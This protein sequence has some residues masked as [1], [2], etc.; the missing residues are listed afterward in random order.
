[1]KIKKKLLGLFA[2]SFFCFTAFTMISCD[3]NS[4]ES[5]NIS[6]E[7]T[8]SSMSDSLS[9]ETHEHEWLEADKITATC[10]EDGVIT[11]IC[12]DCGQSREFIYRNALGHNEVI[13][14][15]K[16]ATCTET[17][18]TEGK[19]CDRCN[20]VLMEQEIVPALDHNYGTLI[21]ETPATCTQTGIIAHYHCDRCAKDFDANKKEVVELTI[22]LKNHEFDNSNWTCDATGHW[23]K[24]KYCNEKESFATHTP[25][26]DSAT[27][28]DDKV[29]TI[30]DYVIQE[31]LGHTH[32]MQYTEK[33]E[34]TCE[35]SGNIAYYQCKG[36]KKYYSDV[37]GNNEITD[38]SSLVISAL[39]HNYG[40]LVEKVEATCEEEGTKAH[41]H[42]D[43]CD[44]YFN[45][46]KV[47]INDLTI[48]ALGHIEVTDKAVSATCE[49]TGLTQGSHCSTCNKVLVKQEV[50]PA[51]GHNEVIDAGKEATCTTTGLTEGKHCDRCG[52]VLVKQEV[53]PAL[54]H[55]EVID[56]KVDATC[57]STGLT[58]GSHCDRC[59]EV[60]IYQEEISYKDH[61]FNN[62][63]NNCTNCGC[64]YGLEYSKNGDSYAVSGIGT[65]KGTEIVIPSLYNGLPVTQIFDSAFSHCSEIEKVVLPESIISI[66]D[67]AFRDCS[68]LSEINI[69]GNV[70]DIGMAA[71][72]ECSSLKN[73][74][75]GKNLSEIGYGAFGYCVNLSD[76][77]VASNNKYFVVEDGG[78]YTK[79]KKE[80]I[81]Y[82][83][84]HSIKSYSI[85]SSVETIRAYA[86]S[87]SCSL[88]TIEIP[89]SISSIDDEVFYGCSS[90][91][92]I[93]IPNSVTSIGESAFYGCSSLT[94]ITIPASVTSIG[95]YAFNGCSS[96]TSITIPDSVTS[97]GYG[98]FYN[99]TSLTSITI[100]E[101][102]TSIDD[103]IFCGCSS[104]ESITIPESVTSIGNYAFD[105]CSSLTSVTIGNSVTSIGDYAFSR[106]SSLTKVYYNGTIEDW[107]N[108]DFKNDSSNPLCNEADL[109]IN[110]QKATNLEI[111]EG[112]KTIANR[113]FLR[114]SSLSSITIPDSVTSIGGYA[115][116]GCVS[117][118][119]VYFEGSMSQWNDILIYY[120][121]SE[122]TNAVIHFAKGENEEFVEYKEKALNDF[123][124][125]KED[126]NDN[127]SQYNYLTNEEIEALRRM[128]KVVEFKDITILATIEEVETE[129]NRV[130][131]ILDNIELLA[132]C[133][134]N[135]AELVNKEIDL[136]SSYG[137]QFTVVELQGIINELISIDLAYKYIDSVF[138]TESKIISMTDADL[139]VHVASLN[140]DK[141]S[142]DK[143]SQKININDLSEKYSIIYKVRV[144]A[145]S[146]IEQ[147]NEEFAEWDLVANEY[148]YEFRLATG[149]KNFM[150]VPTNKTASEVA[151]EA[152]DVDINGE[153]ILTTNGFVGKINSIYNE[154][155]SL[156]L[157]FDSSLNDI[158]KI[159][160]LEKAD[161]KGLSSVH[162]NNYV[163]QINQLGD[164][165]SL[166]NDI[167]NATSYKAVL[168]TYRANV[169]SIV[170]KGVEHYKARTKAYKYIEQNESLWSSTINN[171][172]CTF[173]ETVLKLFIQEGNGLLKETKNNLL[174]NSTTI[175]EVD[176]KQS[177]FNKKIADLIDKYNTINQEQAN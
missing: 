28:Y 69:D 3:E 72:L 169:D 157:A 59:N 84:N 139:L 8:S 22:P 61:D 5:E 14:E 66:G 174:N 142:G 132:Q 133:E 110:N 46:N 129:I 12:V 63:N 11:Y 149:G 37:N 53:I 136:L 87:L 76:I 18:L 161:G 41:Y 124:V 36:C 16:E 155:H 27:E 82:L 145:S 85:P 173:N 105:G 143:K 39:G 162:V 81:L 45:N 168:D 20:E 26:I 121:N 156:W 15:A 115:F 90:L 163:S 166:Y 57:E 17:G 68:S 38:I 100:P 137:N 113:A 167:K 119:D 131:S 126:I 128:I 44:R 118:K 135:E 75:L 24:C 71:F 150:T 40:K 78:L 165:Y 65:A 54:G 148:S 95:I 175:K 154:A 164:I 144:Y 32:V 79:N 107:C 120:G 62:N 30:C 25:N 86:F 104:L 98:A 103:W 130:Y 101:R 106:C 1:M 83:A 176:A 125:F 138:E 159:R 99:C 91:I 52:E 147:V 94:S 123:N 7:Q 56:E 171:Y 21:K 172:A 73:V 74:S 93:I 160:N 10:T 109:Y 117:L 2:L 112:V 4:S 141:I 43:R 77:N 58:Q 92:S 35:T 70:E 134:N 60:F 13:D 88:E 48:P 89:E 51:L 64:T 67:F 108:I 152:G 111:P 47:E 80:F 140:S 34:A 158:I 29:C 23:Y 42:C 177:E 19:H 102:V 96:L 170:E 127:L 33:V 97:I 153:Y 49:G 122:L 151:Y 9:G 55:N 116:F 114:C 6:N 146:R 50:I 31:A